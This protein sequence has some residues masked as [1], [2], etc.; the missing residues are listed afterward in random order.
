[1]LKD[2]PSLFTLILDVIDS[3][4]RGINIFYSSNRK[5]ML[6]KIGYAFLILIIIFIVIAAFGVRQ[7]N[8]SWFADRPNYLSYTSEA[9]PIDFRWAGGPIG[10]HVEA[11]YAIVIPVKIKGLSNKFYFQFDTGSP[12]TF[13]YEKPLRSLQN[14]GVDMQEVQKADKAYIQ[15]LDFDLGGSQIEA[16]MIEIMENYGT[17]FKSHDSTNAIKLGTLGA[18]FMDGRITLID[19]KNKYLE[20]YTERPAW[21]KSLTGFK[22]F[23]FAGRRF[24]LPAIINEVS[25]ELFYDSGASAFGLITSKNRYQDYT[26]EN[27]PE[28]QYEGNRFG[29]SLNIHHKRTDARLEIGNANL[30]L[31]R[32]SYIDMYA[33]FQRFMTPFTRIGGWMGNLPFTE[34]TL[35]LD[36]KKE[37]FIVIESRN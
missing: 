34:K 18:D 31:T 22:P 15:Q 16:E 32:I 14:L 10:D 1:M 36:T 23:D 35:I 17:P 12:T 3:S 30:P 37:E 11:H 26:D 2:F 28:I 6:K 8:N 25:L 9:K 5:K 24:M 4:L 13:L 19:F 7:F 21:M 20:F 27:E 29:E 33:D